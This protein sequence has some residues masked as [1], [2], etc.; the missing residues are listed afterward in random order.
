[1]ATRWRVHP[2]GFHRLKSL[3]RVGCWNVR[4]LV[5]ADGG[6]K[7]ATVRTGPSSVAVDKKIHFLVRE[8]MRFRMGITC[9]SETK[10]FGKDVYEIDGYTVLHSGRD[11]P[12]SGDVLQ[13]GEGVAIVLDPLM[14][15]AW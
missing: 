15:V 8:L 6:V 13:R 14:S 5:E 12:A 9:V 2:G 1:M 7:T 11:L 10:W 4:S 3:L